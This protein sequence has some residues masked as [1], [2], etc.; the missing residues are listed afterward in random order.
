MEN[1]DNSDYIRPPDKV[2]KQKLIDEYD[3][4]DEYDAWFKTNISKPLPLVRDTNDVWKNGS[5]LDRYE[6]ECEYEYEYDLEKAI[7]ESMKD[8]KEGDY[9]DEFLE[10]CIEEPEKPEK[11]EKQVKNVILPLFKANILRLIPFDKQLKELWEKISP[12]L[13]LYQDDK[14]DHHSLDEASYNNIFTIL[15]SIRIS[16]DEFSLLETIFIK[17]I[18]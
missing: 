1:T 14:I 15:K 7:E 4:E 6:Y 10:E 18:N 12:I 17:Q 13:E 8:F 3:D 11:P 5:H 2:I 16:K 9:I